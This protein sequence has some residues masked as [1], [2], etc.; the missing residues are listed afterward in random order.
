MNGKGYVFFG[1]GYSASNYSNR[2]ELYVVN[3]NETIDHFDSEN[4]SN[5]IEPLSEPRRYLTASS[6]IVDGKGYVF[7]IGGEKGNKIC[8]T[9]VDLYIVNEDGNIQHGYSRDDY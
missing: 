4:N 2:V 8:S 1:G 9:V 3:E 6:V 7:F 5:K